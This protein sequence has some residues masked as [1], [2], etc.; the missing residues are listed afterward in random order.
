MEIFFCYSP[1][2][3]CDSFLKIYQLK[4]FIIIFQ[5]L[6]KCDIV[7]V[8]WLPK[9]QTSLRFRKVLC[10]KLGLRN[11]YFLLNFGWVSTV[12]RGEIGEHYLIR[13]SLTTLKFDSSSQNPLHL[14]NA[15]QIKQRQKKRKTLPCHWPFFPVTTVKLRHVQSCPRCA[16][17]ARDPLI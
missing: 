14:L 7:N 11:K 6:C 8:Y 9:C 4:Y 17:K 12:L 15:P 5:E 13:K 16:L 10:N 1:F 2:S 3:T